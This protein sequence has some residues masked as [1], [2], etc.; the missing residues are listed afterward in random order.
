MG[1]T[2]S[3][4]NTQV[5]GAAALPPGLPPRGESKAV[6]L[7]RHGQ[8][9]HNPRENPLWLF[10]TLVIRDPDLTPKGIEQA[11]A[12]SKL[13]VAR[14]WLPYLEVC[15]ISPMSRAV[16]TAKLLFPT[17]ES[18]ADA[19]LLPLELCPLLTEHNKLMCDGGS[20][21]NE[22]LPRHPFLTSPPWRALEK[23]GADDNQWWPHLGENEAQLE[24]RVEHFKR[25]LASRPESVICCVG[26]GAFF[27][28]LAGIKLP[29]AEPRWAE[30]TADGAFVLRPEWDTWQ[31]P[32]EMLARSRA[33]PAAIDQPSHFDL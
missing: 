21:K 32:Q 3:T 2:L 14:S 33:A 23:L 28:T 16:H 24:E 26:H 30:L 5:D 7:I 22:L 15:L 31:P 1:N 20:R 9:Q 12:A 25:E 18:D 17:A 29:N 27:R 6:L 19:A 13:L 8:A 4:T 10:N 11:T